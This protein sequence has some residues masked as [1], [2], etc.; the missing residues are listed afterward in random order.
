MAALADSYAA[1]AALGKSLGLSESLLSLYGL[2]CQENIIV[3][4]GYTVISS[5]H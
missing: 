1:C 3:T 4:V 5:I 2:G